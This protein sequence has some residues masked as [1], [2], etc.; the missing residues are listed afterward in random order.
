MQTARSRIEM[1]QR[2]LGELDSILSQAQRDLNTVAGRERVAKWKAKVIPIFESEL[3]PA[4]AKRMAGT[5]PG[6]SFTSDLLEE[7][8]DEVEV[9]R[10][11]LLQL[12]DEFKRAPSDK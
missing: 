9:Y 2:H 4:I 7:L 6:P 5:A 8:G 3:G 11:F 10:T 1:L 12:I